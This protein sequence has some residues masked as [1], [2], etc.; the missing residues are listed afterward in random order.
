MSAP[1]DQQ[2]RHARDRLAALDRERAETRAT[3]AELER[4]TGGPQM[5]S[6]EER[7][8]LF[9]SL[10][11][12]RPDVFATR[13]ESRTQAGR[14]GWAPRCDNEWK[15]GVCEKPRVKCAAC[16][17]RR[18]V[19]FS[20]VEVRRHLEGRQTIGIYPLLSDETCRLVAIDLDGPTW[21]EDATALREAAMEAGAPVLVERS[22]SGRG[23][24]VWVLFSRPVAAR[25]AR[26]IGSWLLTQA[27]SRRSI[28]MDSYDRLFPNQDTMPTGGFGNLIALPLQHARRAE[29]CTVFLDDA[30]EPYI[31]QWTYLAGVGLFDADRAQALASES[32]RTGG[33]LGLAHWTDATARPRPR[34]LTSR[35]AT[36]TTVAVGLGGRVEI[37]LAGLPVDLRDRLRRTAAFANPEFFERERARLS[38]HKTPRVIA[39]H[40][41]PGDMLLLPRG[42]LNA[43]RD[44]LEH[45]AVTVVIDDARTS[46]FPIDAAFTGTLSADQRAAVDAL[47]GHETGVLVAPPGSGKTVMATAL[48]AR[49]GCSTLVLVHRRPLLEQWVKRLARFLDLDPTQIGS[50]TTEPGSSGVDVAM[51]QTL[52]RREDTVAL[53]G[54]YG[55]LVVDECHHVPAVSVE[56]LLREVPAR[57]VTGL[58][59]TPRRRD[60]HHPIISMQ[61][62]PVRHTL[63][64][65]H[66]AETAVRR[67]VVERRTSFDPAVLPTDPG[68]QEILSA[69]ASDPERT[70]RIA[71]DVVAEL[72][73]GRY[74]LVLTERRA[75]LDA[76]AKLLEPSVTRLIVLHGGMGVRARRHADELLA[77][78]EPRVV[79]ATGR[80]IGEGFDDP[81]LDTLVLAMPIAWKGT[82]TQYAGRLHRHHDAKHEIRI[83]D[84]VDHEIPVLRRMYAKRQ[85][86]YAKLGYRT[87]DTQAT[88]SLALT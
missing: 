39:C 38:T 59:A 85:R 67:V 32:E 9:A 49:R 60:G 29:G 34:P 81:R 53:L 8:A 7:V 63:I 22:R 75:Q 46:G 18:F 61:C 26:A 79:L 57:H 41:Q 20:E 15:P 43:A 13:W 17:H 80:Y 10:F 4:L 12:G 19:A 52:T 62:G 27:M 78:T 30:L 40:Q 42:C 1:V 58:T 6:A 21:K 77:Q 51:V 16:T 68:I 69:I 82:M 48:I 70:K 73:E 55:H 87:A 64:R 3:I 74:P 2:L 23:A 14:S 28:S 25:A 54:R 31:D 76:L 44:E 45:A 88:I 50:P 86:A 24:H 11:R 72:A 33:A 71:D 66:A 36:P 5:A 35:V 84:Y 37:P 47:A 83:L 65:T 56:R